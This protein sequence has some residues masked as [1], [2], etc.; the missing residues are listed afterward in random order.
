MLDQKTVKKIKKAARNMKTENDTFFIEGDCFF[1][2][3][4][5]SGFDWTVNGRLY[6]NCTLKEI[7]SWIDNGQN[8]KNYCY[9]YGNV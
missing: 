6:K 4:N 9:D 2:R 3:W 8:I 5:G 7:V 1:C